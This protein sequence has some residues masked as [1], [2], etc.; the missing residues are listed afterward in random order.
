MASE[1][2]NVLVISEDNEL[3]LEQLDRSDWYNGIHRLLNGAFGEVVHCRGLPRPQVMLVDDCRAIN[4]SVYN[5]LASM[6][7][8][9][10]IYGPALIVEEGSW[11]ES[12]T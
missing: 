12:P 8:R 10:P 9:G 1:K 4:G 2:W 6:L 5:P 7:Y 3:W 11:T